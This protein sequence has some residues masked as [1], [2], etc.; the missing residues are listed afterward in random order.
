MQVI[1]TYGALGPEE[2]DKGSFPGMGR[3]MEVFGSLDWEGVDVMWRKIIGRYDVTLTS[4]GPYCASLYLYQEL[5][6]IVSRLR[7][8][9]EA[10]L[11]RAAEDSAEEATPGKISLEHAHCLLAIEDILTDY[12]PYFSDLA[13]SDVLLDD[14]FSPKV[15]A[16]VDVLLEQDLATSRGIVFVDQRQ[17]ALC[18]AIVLPRL[19]RLQGG[20]RCASFIGQNPSI[21]GQNPGIDGPKAIG[22][23]R[24]VA[25]EGTG[26]AARGDVERWEGVGSGGRGTC[27]LRVYEHIA[28]SR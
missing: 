15:H 5:S 19:S 4:L 27:M 17:V 10:T 7:P 23:Q 9:A 25:R 6:D 28:C 2:V 21:D 11:E 22:S 3:C 24:G 16:L 13:A 1:K 20:V 12:E 26:E 8:Q 14:W 18:L